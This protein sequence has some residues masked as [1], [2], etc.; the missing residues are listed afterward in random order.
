MLTT[1]II[2]QDTNRNT[3]APANWSGKLGIGKHPFGIV[4][5]LNRKKAVQVNLG[6]KVVMFN[7]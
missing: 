6:L 2:R 5:E 7:N 4:W 1:N 3:E